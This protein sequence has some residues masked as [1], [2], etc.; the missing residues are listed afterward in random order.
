MN[1]FQPDRWFTTVKAMTERL[2]SVST[3]SPDVEGENACAR[4]ITELLAEGQADSLA[5]ELWPVADGRHN[6]ACLL[7]SPAP[8]RQ[9]IILM[10]HYDTV[11]IDEFQALDPEQGGAIARDPARLRAA[12]EGGLPQG[13][14]LEVK[15][16][17]EQTWQRPGAEREPVWMFGRG[18]VDMKSGLSINIALLRYFAEHSDELGGNL[19]L[20]ACPDEENE[21]AGILGALPYLIELQ[22][23]HDLDYIGVINTDYTA[24]RGSDDHERYIYTGV[25]GKLLP[26]FYILGDPTHVGE[27]F[28]GVDANQIAAELVRRLN[29]NTRLSDSW[30]PDGVAPLEV[31]VPP[32]TLKLRDLKP[33][34][35]VQTSAEAFVYINWL[36]YSISPAQAL[37]T[38]EAEAT[39]ALLSVLEAR[40]AQFAAFR[41]HE[42][43]PKQ[44]AP[45]VLSYA[46][47]CRR[48]RQKRGWFGAKGEVA[49]AE[50]LDALVRSV[51]GTETLAI[52]AATH[53]GDAREISQQI[54]AR[55]AREAELTGPAVIVFFAPP[56]YPHIQPQAHPLVDAIAALIDDSDVNP[57]GQIHLRGFYP[58]IADISYVRL[59]PTVRDHLPAL[60][61]NMPLFDHGY[62]LAFDQMAA[63]DCPVVNI[64]PFGKDAHGLFERVHMPY[65]FRVVPEFV[66]HTILGAFAGTAS[67]AGEEHE[68][69]LARIA[70]RDVAQV[71]AAPDAP[72]PIHLQVAS[73]CSQLQT[74]LV[75]RPGSEIDLLDLGNKGRLLFEDIPFLR[76]MQLEHD[77]FCQLLRDQGIEAL[78]LD[79]LVDDILRDERTRSAAVEWLCRA[80]G[81][82][83]LSARLLNDYAP[84]ALRALL[85]EGMGED[86]PAFLADPV[87]NAYFTRDPGAVIGDGYIACKAQFDARVRETLI[88]QAVVQ[89]HP[90]F[91]GVEIVYGAQADEGRPFTIEGGDI[92]V[93][94]DETV[95]IGC[96]QRTRSETVGMLARKLFQAGKVQRVYEVHI[97]S[98]RQ[99]MHLDTVFTVIAHG[100]I[101]VYPDVMDQIEIIKRYEPTLTRDGELV[102]LPIRENR[103][104]YTLLSDE[105]AAPL[106]VVNTGNN[107]ARYAAREQGADGTNVFAIAPGRVIS[108]DR[109]LHTNR[110]MRAL[111][112]EVLEIEGSELVRGMGGPRCLALPLRRG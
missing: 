19:L 65:S 84:D 107:D 47:L 76:K 108:Y 86:A 62:S 100:V 8:T 48:V 104:F 30:S 10:A 81:A 53:K 2:M 82:P 25:V 109:N 95:V 87:P 77:A 1:A 51:S 26:S 85:F 50:W 67:G 68:T 36:T 27:P 23:A 13:A 72:E 59:D 38:M 92:L 110:A 55:L 39:A 21:S 69:F 42:P 49:F 44:Y 16:D 70:A 90:L 91:A 96:S 3:I 43:Q 54:V 80:G 20:L 40:D 63:L 57:H 15:R 73:E 33:S 35:N 31:A 18:S 4:L 94:N 22:A 5:P 103:R 6:V 64:G 52:P 111:G 41:G 74:V 17:L 45:L 61:D 11:G 32:V 83:E 112:I 37:A 75:H 78:Y 102:A 58:Y 46:D 9:T 56:F 105:F 99:Y 60:I 88:L 24:P 7:R 89:W 106:T 12:L 66:Y 98:A 101:V 79:Q 29:L 28:R 71:P 34:Y 93:L 14:S 97:P